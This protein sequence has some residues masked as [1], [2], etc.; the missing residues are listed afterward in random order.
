MRGMNALR[1]GRH[2]NSLQVVRARLRKLLT[3]I[4]R[5]RIDARETN[6][7]KWIARHGRG[8]VGVWNAHAKCVAMDAAHNGAS[9]WAHG[10]CKRVKAGVKTAPARMRV[11][12][13]AAFKRGPKQF[14]VIPRVGERLFDFVF[15][16]GK[17]GEQLAE[18]SVTTEQALLRLRELRTK[19]P[20]PGDVFGRKLPTTAPAREVQPKAAREG[21]LEQLLW[22]GGEQDEDAARRRLLQR[23]EKRVRSLSVQP[24]GCD[25]DG[26]FPL[27]LGGL[28]V[29]RVNQL[30]D[31]VH[32]D[33]PRLHLGP[34]PL[35]VGVVG[36]IN[37]PAREAHIAGVHRSAAR[38]ARLLA[39]QRLGQGARHSFELVEVVAREQIRVRE[40]PALQAALE[41]CDGLLLSWKIRER[42]AEIRLRHARFGEVKV[43]AR[44]NPL[45]AGVLA[46]TLAR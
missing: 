43:G 46:D 24:V 12:G 28:E 5:Q 40:P 22:L 26:D 9:E 19:V 21:R 1:R 39:V 29:D 7:S 37:L 6:K 44:G 33:L 10:I 20:Q 15:Q 14:G 16:Y 13:K 18:H 38:A 25:D 31:L 45:P 23:L 8:D 36:V 34:Y 32:A 3:P 17:T 42:H 11:G 41:Q 27:G 4:R 2:A 30:A 35:H